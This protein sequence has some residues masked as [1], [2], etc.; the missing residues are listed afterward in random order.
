MEKYASLSNTLNSFQYKY[1]IIIINNIIITI[2]LFVIKN[3]EHVVNDDI[4]K[5]FF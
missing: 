4:S 5:L 1:I 3:C 2:Y